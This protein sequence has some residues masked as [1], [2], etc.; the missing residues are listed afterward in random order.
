M[1]KAFRDQ[2]RAFYE[3]VVPHER[4]VVPDELALQC[5]EADEKSDHEEQDAADP[6]LLER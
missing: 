4:R 3:G 1:S 2:H 6:G 5:G